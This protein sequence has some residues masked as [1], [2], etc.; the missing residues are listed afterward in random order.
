MDAALALNA[1]DHLYALA[2]I[3]N[4]PN[5][6]GLSDFN[7]APQLGNITEVEMVLYTREAGRKTDR[8][9]S[10][11]CPIGKLCQE[12]HKRTECPYHPRE[13]VRDGRLPS[14]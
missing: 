5:K 6:W 4:N 3:G 13:Q 10:E 7:F 8:P 12:N 1:P 11:P 9:G 14:Y 2:D